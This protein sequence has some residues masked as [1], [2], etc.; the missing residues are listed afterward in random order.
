MHIEL[1]LDRRKQSKD[2]R[3]PVKVYI[4]EHRASR[5][6]ATGFFC[7]E[8][9]FDSI[10]GQLIGAG[11]KRPNQKLSMIMNRAETETAGCTLV[12]AVR[13]IRAICD[14]DNVNIITLGSFWDKVTARYST[15]N[16]IGNYKAALNRI[17]RF[18]DPYKVSFEDITFQWLNELKQ[19][20]SDLSQ[21]SKVQIFRC[22]RHVINVAIDEDVTSSYPFK[23]FVIRGEETRKRCLSVASLRLLR[24]KELTG[25]ALYARD[26]FML[27]FY[28]IGINPVDLYS[29]EPVNDGRACY[30]RAKTKKLYDIKVEPE[31]QEL[32]DK[33]KGE[34]RCVNASER[35]TT[36]RNFCDACGTQLRKIMP[37][38]SLYWARHTWATLA[39]ELDIPMDTISAALG[40]SFG[41]SVTNVYVKRNGKKVDDANRRVL[42]YLAGKLIS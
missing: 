21:N 30:R 2:G 36:V 34:D 5:M 41:L 3:Y 1:K 39:A 22:L 13:R 29:L 19:S 32:I 7:K 10:N 24:D 16:T 14:F 9:E 20:M 31:A 23:K 4:S 11:L 8:N 37:D 25:V 38:L 18:K 27:S 17:S 33:Y 15:E 42:D 26:M 12:E 35:Y 6:V 40:H 28:L